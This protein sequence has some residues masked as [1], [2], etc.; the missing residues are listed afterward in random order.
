MKARDVMV[1]EV[2][3]IGPHADIAEAEKLMIAHD[4]SALPVVDADE[5]VVG[6]LSEADFLEREE[7]AGERL[8][9]D[10]FE[11]LFSSKKLAEGYAKAHGKRVDQLMSRQLI[12][13]REDT[14]LDEVAALL[15]RHHIK[16]V[17]ILRDGRLVGIV[18]R[19][20]LIQALASGKLA[21]HPTVDDD[22]ALRMEILSR[23]EQQRW[24]QFG[25]R[26][27]VVQNGTVHLWGLVSSA[28][29]RRA[30]VALC[31]NVPGVTTVVDEMI[32]GY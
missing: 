17:P 21:T 6:M 5:H 9:V 19:R 2:I 3:T 1:R 10:W 7:L 23:L 14:P 22:H 18:S 11:S 27:V 26:N 13:A 30:L 32:A 8:H 28:E 29:E 24:T 25:G 12:S 31:E 16:R 20:N 15:E 4:V